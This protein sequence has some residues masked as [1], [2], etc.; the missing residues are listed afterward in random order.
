M[1][2]TFVTLAFSICVFGFVAAQVPRTISY[3]G[4]YTDPSGNPVNGSPHKV[5]FRFFDAVSNTENTSLAREIE[6]ITINKGVISVTIG[7]GDPSHTTGPD[8]GALPPDVWMQS[9]KVQVFVDGTSIGDQVPLTTVPYAF[10][11]GSVDGANITGTVA[12]TKISG[13]LPGS[14]VGT[15]IN[16]SNITTGTIS[17]ALFADGSI[18]GTKLALDIN[19]TNIASGTLS[20]SRLESTLDVTGVNTSGNITTGGG[21]HVGGTSDPG[22]DNLL[23]DG[24]IT[25]NGSGISA[26]NA[27][28]L[29][30]GTV[31]DAR[32]ETTLDITGVNTSGNITTLG[33]VHV[34]GT[35]DPG[36][37]NLVVDGTIT[38]NGSGI[39]AINASSISSGTIS[40]ARL[41]TNVDVTGFLTTVGGVHVGGVSDPGVDNLVVDGTIT[42]NGS[43]IS[44]IN[45]SNISAGILSDSRLESTVDLSALNVGSSQFAV[46]SAGNI[47]KIKNLTYDFPASHNSGTTFLS[48]NG[49]GTLS[50]SNS[51]SGSF[52]G[53]GI[54]ASNITTGTLPSSVLDA[55][56]Q[57]LADGSLSNTVLDADLQDLAADGIITNLNVSGTASITTSL[58]GI[59]IGNNNSAEGDHSLALGS[60]ARLSNTG[61]GSVFI[62]DRSVATQTS[63]TA[64]NRFYARFDNGYFFYTNAALSA[65]VFV[66][67]GGTSWTTVSDSTK[68]E[69]F[70]TVDGENVLVK[71]RGMKLGTWNYKFNPT[72]I[73]HYGPYAQEF[74]SLFGKD[75][76]GNISSDTAIVSQDISGLNLTAIQALV[77]R[78]DELNATIESMQARIMQ[79]ENQLAEVEELKATMKANRIVMQA[80]STN[81]RKERRNKKTSI[82]NTPLSKK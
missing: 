33:G 80:A 22:A 25:G 1:K 55:D 47:T 12:T 77:K 34:G 35:S 10:V 46:S 14:Q 66:G 76:I 81:T 15:G 50:W 18:P 13:T 37:D 78:T 60:Y 39:S 17:P 30:T 52:V 11:A 32:L 43:G 62:G 63:G 5:T 45:A 54:S 69:N 7:A 2:K 19:A 20:D 73:R 75:G 71:I 67:S 79:M 53:S 42:G 48:N 68:K 72:S 61:D 6:N 65:N 24:I 16:A 57:D 26:L 59:A 41:E 70:K 3:Q 51:I 28:N 4:F 38:G 9:Y 74:Y 29:A 8:N 40:D 49:S 56:L 27:S 21:L 44:S 64:V 82:I 23:V 31:S 36:T 58:N